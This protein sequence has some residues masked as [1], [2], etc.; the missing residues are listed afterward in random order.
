M[1]F[2]NFKFLRPRV[3]IADSGA[4][5]VLR[6]DGEGSRGFINEFDKD[7]SGL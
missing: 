5:A 6:L 4:L 3:V 7:L 2:E 1:P